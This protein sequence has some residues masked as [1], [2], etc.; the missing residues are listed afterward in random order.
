MADISD[1]EIINI[2]DLIEL[3]DANEIG[4]DDLKSI[5]S[6]F[7]CAKNLDVEHFLK[8]NSIEFSRKHQS[9]TYL[10]L[11]KNTAELVGYYTLA[12]KAITV[13][14]NDMSNT[15]KRK[16]ERVA[17]LEP[18]TNTFNIPAYLLAQFGKNQNEDL[19]EKIDGKLL[20]NMAMS[21]VEK[22]QH[23]VGGVL[24]FL[25]TENND[26]L[27]NFYSKNGNFRVFNTLASEND[28][29][30]MIQMLKTM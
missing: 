25:E 27:I 30:E 6:D 10:V 17:R 5:L 1:F 29:Y 22:L 3:V 7:N 21:N 2:L 16:C 20:L 23:D 14:A 8:E 12:V 13:R 18:S 28:G 19:Q 9:I 11:S 4:E 26:K 15:L 24:M